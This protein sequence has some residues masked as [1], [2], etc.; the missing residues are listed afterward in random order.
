MSKIWYAAVMDESDNDWG[1]GSF[2]FDEATKIAKGYGENSQVL[3]IDGGYDESGNATTDPI[4][5]NIYKN[6]IDF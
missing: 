3:A 6:G 2:N 1:T 4:C 5:I